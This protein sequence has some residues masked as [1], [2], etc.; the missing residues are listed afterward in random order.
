[1]S[2]IFIS[3]IGLEERGLGFFK[4]KWDFKI[5]D[6]ILFINRE[7]E[8]DERV[9]SIRKEITT[10][11]L[12]AKKFQIL[13]ASYY[14][15]F[16]IVHGFNQYVFNKK[17]DIKSSKFFWDVSNFNRQNLLVLMWLL[18]KKYSVK[19]LDVFYTVPKEYNP[20]ISKGAKGFSTTP[21]FSGIFSK[22][23]EKLLILL[24][25][26][27]IDRPLY[28]FNVIEPSK[29]ILVQGEEPTDA[30]FLEANRKAVEELS[31]SIYG[32]EI[33]KAPADDPHKAAQVLRS[34]F[35]ENAREYNIIAS[36]LNTKL[37]T[38]GLYLACEENPDVQVVYSFP[39]KFSGWLSRGIKKVKRF[40]L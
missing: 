31:D 7:F 9:V 34:I 22:G 30:S 17:L 5:D 38:V 13:R 32:I 40:K 28:L 8:N 24:M 14:D 25:G 29:V 23:K 37:Q 3:M 35:N 20:K 26:Y 27:E 36:P 33:R 15:P 2:N 10:E 18:R 6:H 19:S 11:F 21:F 1:M 12:Q 16:E 39:D 4:E